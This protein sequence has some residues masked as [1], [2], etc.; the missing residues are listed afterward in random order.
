MC[1]EPGPGSKSFLLS[2]VCHPLE[3]ALGS[4][5]P[6][7]EVGLVLAWQLLHCL[8][9]AFVTARNSPGLLQGEFNLASV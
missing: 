2:S 5:L 7:L 4:E 1:S 6:V 9:Q 8:A 3:H